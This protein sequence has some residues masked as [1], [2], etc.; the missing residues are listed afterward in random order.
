MKQPH[1]KN[2]QSNQT[3][4]GEIRKRTYAAAVIAE[5]VRRVVD[6]FFDGVKRSH[7]VRVVVDEKNAPEGVPGDS[8]VFEIASFLKENANVIA[9]G[10]RTCNWNNTRV[11]ERVEPEKLRQPF[12][13][14]AGFD[15]SE[16]HC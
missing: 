15:E 16:R 1:F 4:E 13:L 7:S 3:Q 12:T 8:V 11:A 9:E 14:L 6:V 5:G 10:T 2:Q